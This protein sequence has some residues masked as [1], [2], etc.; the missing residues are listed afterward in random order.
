MALNP[1]YEDELS[2]LRE[3]GRDFAL[4]N[5]KLAGF[6]GRDASDPDVERLLEGFAFLV[7][8][9]RQRLDTEY[10]EFVHGLLRL[11]WPHYLRPIPPITMVQ[12]ET[13]AASSP[14]NVVIAAG[15]GVGS[16]PIEGTSCVFRT[17]Y[18][19]EVLP[20]VI[21]DPQLESRSTSG[22]LI[23]QLKVKGLYT[24]ACL[25]GGRLRLFFETE[26]EP[27]VGRILLTWLMRNFRQ[28]TI[29][30]AGKT[31]LTLGPEAI[32]PVGFGENDAILP[33][34][35]NSF[36]GFR[37][38]QEYLAYPNKYLF[39]DVVG[40]EPLAGVEGGACTFTFDF[41]R[42]FPDHIRVSD[43]QI[44]LNCTP[45]INL[46]AHEA[47]PI[48][49]ERS[50]TEYRV[51]PAGGTAN[52][53]IHSI[54]QVVGY[55]QGQPQRI[56]Y[57]PFDS[58]RHDLPGNAR[59]QL[60]FRER[61]RPA[62]V[63]RGVDHY[64]SFVNR[65]DQH[66]SPRIEVASLHLTCS[67]GPLAD[68]LPVGSVDQGTP[69]TPQSVT[70]TN[71]TGIASEVQPPIGD[72]LTWK[73]VA[74]LARNYGALTDVDAIKTVISAYDFKAA[75][76]TQ[77]RRRLELL[78][79]GLDS[80]ASSDGNT[81][82]R[83]IPARVRNIELSLNESKIGGEGELF[84]FGSVLDAFFAG[85]AGI[86]MLHQFSVRGTETSVSYKWPARTGTA[87]TL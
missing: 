2:Y 15:T 78:L 68:R 44:R 77:A 38:M 61:V 64:V 86:N 43:G 36:A 9:L 12:F 67:N 53:T 29:A 33:W 72:N 51:M 19:V 82:L 63:G 74:N 16:R 84:L 31:V 79:E 71:I 21:T 35:V 39:V 20:L 60:F 73:L 37:L 41:S 1:Y 54:N 58:L 34:P 23:F 18:P 7:A 6:L 26:R 75:Q 30:V 28:C 45:A 13:A 4:A 52:Y 83:G 55:V 80:F 76:D 8:R 17:C 47:A 70:F 11:I 85:Y 24:F 5:P 25:E 62:V 66:K 10:P 48:R 49:I 22:R 14:K 81:V 57:V 46:V 59:E 32:R 65:L 40:L 42:P 3:L 56:E 50:K 87:R 27:Q 69:D